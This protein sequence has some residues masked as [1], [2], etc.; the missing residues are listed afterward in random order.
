ME[1]IKPFGKVAKRLVIEVDIHGTARM[2]ATNVLGIE[3]SPGVRPL[4]PVFECIQ[5][6]AK[7]LNDVVGMQAKAGASR[8]GLKQQETAGDG[9][10]NNAS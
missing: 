5:I 3:I 7:V 6:L 9:G 1:I 4:M 8:G 2:E 10:G